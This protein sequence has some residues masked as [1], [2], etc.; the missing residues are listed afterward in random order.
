LAE[1]G[2]GVVGQLLAL[3]VV[4]PEGGELPATGGIP[5]QEGELGPG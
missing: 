1:S 4:Q 5:G 3:V 2:Y